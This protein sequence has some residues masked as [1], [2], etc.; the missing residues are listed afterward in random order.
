M[1]ETLVPLVFPVFFVGMWL[2]VTYLLGHMSGWFRL[3]AA[4]PDRQEEPLQ[5]FRGQSGVMGGG[6]PGGVAMNGIL[7]LS[8]CPGGLRVG[9]MKIFGL[10]QRDFFVLW[11]EVAITRGKTLFLETAHLTFG[12]PPHGRLRISGKLADRIAPHAQG[13]WRGQIVGS[14]EAPRS[15]LG[16]VLIGWAL[17]TAVLAAIALALPM[18]HPT[19]KGPPLAV[20]VLFPS[21]VI[22]LALLYRYFARR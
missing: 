17:V 6:F 2:L 15:G 4:Y 16:G 9:V 11:P 19:G 12:D 20:M 7:N 22:G 5:R 13:P 18:L 8:P 3:M 14:V 21:A 10:F 1:F